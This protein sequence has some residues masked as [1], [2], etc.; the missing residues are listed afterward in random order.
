LAKIQDMREPAD[1]EEVSSAEDGVDGRCTVCLS[2]PVE[3]R[4]TACGHACLCA[5]CA[6]RIAVG[7]AKCPICRADI[8][9]V[10]P[11]SNQ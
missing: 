7:A 11:V 2:L 6:S 5:D 8:T 1:S 9:F 10:A 4:L 3:V